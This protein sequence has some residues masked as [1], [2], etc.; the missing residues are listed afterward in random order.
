MNTALLALFICRRHFQLATHT[1]Q[2][3][4]RETKTM[5]WEIT[6]ALQRSF[7][8][9]TLQYWSLYVHYLLHNRIIN[10]GRKAS[11]RKRE[12]T[13]GFI[14]MSIT[15]GWKGLFKVLWWTGDDRLW[16]KK[17]KNLLI[18]ACARYLQERN[19]ASA[20]LINVFQINFVQM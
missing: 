7:L 14:M 1:E 20:N 9:C 8:K 3:E 19:D 12:E 5:L 17:T 15:A 18:E 6:Q 2:G 13:S 11:G 4:V 16:G 10:P